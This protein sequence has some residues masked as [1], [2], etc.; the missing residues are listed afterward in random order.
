[1][2][3]YQ[4]TKALYLSLT[5]IF[6]LRLLVFTIILCLA[7]FFLFFLEEYWFFGFSLYFYLLAQ[8]L[9]IFLIG[10]VFWF[11]VYHDRIDKLYRTNED[12]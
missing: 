5:R 6:T 10:F 9:I 11:S 4:N 12:I 3:K 2:S 8:G 7:P 1:M